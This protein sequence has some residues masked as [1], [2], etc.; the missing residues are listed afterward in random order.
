[1]GGL[2]WLSGSLGRSSFGGL[3]LFSLGL[4]SRFGLELNWSYLGNHDN[5]K[6]ALFDRVVRKSLCV[7]VH[8]LSVG[9][10]LLEAGF[11]PVLFLDLLLQLL[12][13]GLATLTVSESSTSRGSCFPCRV[14]I[15]IFI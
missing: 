2:S 14:F 4:G 11:E 10:Q 5:Q 6:V 3:G 12:D 1:M 15:E 8:D 7:V 9:N 13:L